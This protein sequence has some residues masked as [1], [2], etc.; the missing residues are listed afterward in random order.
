MTQVSG[1]ILN[2]FEQ[3]EPSI[4][5]K[6]AT[7]FPKVYSLGPLHTLLKTT[8]MTNSSSP[9]E[10]GRL[11][12]EDRSCIT[13]LDH[14]K[15]KSVLYVSF[16]TVVMLSHEQ[17]LEFW[18]GL[19]NSLKPFLW[20][21]QKDLINGEGGLGNSVPLELEQGTKE[22]GLLVDWAPQ[23]EVLA[24]PALGGFLTHCGW[25]STL[26]CIA[27]GVPMLCWPSIA[28]QMINRRCVSEQWRIG[29]D[30]NG[31]C[32]RLTVEKRVRYIMENHKEELM[33]S[34][35]EIAEKARDSIKENGSSY[36]NL[37]NLIKDIRPMEVTTSIM[38]K[39]HFVEK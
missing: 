14:Q 37:E 12:Q 7:I 27:E 35:N 33:I 5:T 21:I 19:V 4:I 1:L 17:L 9:H 2:T 28:D 22:R 32:D 3:L 30:M 29:L 15:A 8:V 39:I 24:H 20:V 36:R 10:D 16:G 38:D 11:R 25:N 6:L 23:E 26:E 13:W 31:T 18:H 34:A